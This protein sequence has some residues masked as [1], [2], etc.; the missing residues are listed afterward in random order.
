M[1]DWAAALEATSLAA[2]L[3]Q[4]VWVYPL[5]NAGHIL[6]IALLVGCVIPMDMALLRRGAIAPYAGLRRYAVAGFLLA[7]VC[8]ALMFVVQARD[9]LQ[10]PWF[11]A[12]IALVGLA[13]INAALH[14]APGKARTPRLAA[15]ASLLLWIAALVCGRM[16]G[17]R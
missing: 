13:A 6:G 3:R 16:I 1:T 8:G 7:A 12:K 9:Y 15:K 11:A 14:L 5:V 10:S 2:G 17:Y 4:S